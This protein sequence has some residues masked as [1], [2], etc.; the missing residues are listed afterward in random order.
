MKSSPKSLVAERWVINASPIIALARVGQVELLSRLP[1]RAVVP[2]AVVDELA[3]APES[4][5]ARRAIESGLCQIV[6]TTTPP[7]EL[8]AWDLGSG[9]TAVLAHAL[10]HPKWVAILDDGMARRCARSFSLPMKG[11]LAVILLAKQHGLI[12]SA[13]QVLHALRGADFRLDDAVIQDALARTVGEAWKSK[14]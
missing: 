1:A 10:A 3:Q 11:T 14:K 5:P 4:D 6:P 2:Q 12:E 8:L 7:K 9:E 13:A